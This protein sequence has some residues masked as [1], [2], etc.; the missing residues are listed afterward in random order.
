MIAS[1]LRE[2]DGLVSIINE[3][4][5]RNG[6]DPGCEGVGYD[7]KTLEI[8]TADG[9]DLEDTLNWV[10][11]EMCLNNE[12]KK[13]TKLTPEILSNNDFVK[14]FKG[15]RSPETTYLGDDIYVRIDEYNAVTPVNQE[16]GDSGLYIIASDVEFLI[17]ALTVCGC[18]ALPHKLINYVGCER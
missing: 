9:E 4:I 3:L 14:E 7:P 10:F 18:K 11:S 1:T 6:Y 12:H 16:S 17:T 8:G 2:A 5:E 15:Y 13:L